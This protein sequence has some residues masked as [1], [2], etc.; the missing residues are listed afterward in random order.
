MFIISCRHN[1]YHMCG[2]FLLVVPYSEVVER[3]H[4]DRVL[5]KYNTSYNIAPGQNVP[6]VLRDKDEGIAVLDS[7]KW[8]L[9]PFWAKDPKIG[10]R[11]INARIETIAEKPSFRNALQKRR[12]IIVASGF[13]EW[14]KTG[15][16]KGPRY[17]FM[18]ERKVF[19]F[20]GLWERWKSPGG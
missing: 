13:Y 4:I 3:F 19:G 7:F 16:D 2:R 9:V 17:F 18:P 8:G 1:D 5:N 12:C 15:D 6:V 10:S 14:K 11:M 20:A